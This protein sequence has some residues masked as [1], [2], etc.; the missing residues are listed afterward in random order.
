MW[1]STKLPLACAI[2]KAESTCAVLLLL[3]STAISLLLEPVLL[4]DF[5]FVGVL[6]IEK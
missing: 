5:G 4:H 3:G 1:S 6:S 2:N